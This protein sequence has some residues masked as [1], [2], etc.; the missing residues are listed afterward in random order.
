M[1]FPRPV[2]DNAPTDRD[3]MAE[4]HCV[5]QMLSMCPSCRAKMVFYPTSVRCFLHIIDYISAVYNRSSENAT[6]YSSTLM[7]ILFFFFDEQEAFP[8]AWAQGPHLRR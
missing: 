1:R 8:A 3:S 7:E 5:A 2:R 6:H 4:P